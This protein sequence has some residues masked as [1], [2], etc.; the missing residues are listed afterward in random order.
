[1]FLLKLCG[2]SNF[3]LAK[4]LTSFTLTSSL[5][6][7]FAKLSVVGV[8]GTQVHHPALTQA[9]QQPQALPMSSLGLVWLILLMHTGH[10]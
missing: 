6:E 4:S 9:Q 8:L 3:T 2:Q 7:A 10:E 5:R 1:M